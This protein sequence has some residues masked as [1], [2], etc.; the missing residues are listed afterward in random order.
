MVRRAGRWRARRVEARAR[1]RRRD[2]PARTAS[3]PSIS[4]WP[5][6][7]GRSQGLSDAARLDAPPDRSSLW[8]GL[9]DLRDTLLG[10]TVDDLRALAARRP[11]V[12]GDRCNGMPPRITVVG[13]VNLDLVVRG[14]AAAAAGGDGRRRRRSRVPG[15]KGANQA[16]ACAR[17][18]ADVTLV[19]RG[20]ARPFA[21]EALAGLREGGVTL[22]AARTDAAD[23]SRGDPGRRGGRDHDRGRARRQRGA[24][25]G[26]AAAA[27]RGA[28]PARG[29]RRGG[30]RGLGGVRRALLPERRARAA[31][32]LS[33]PT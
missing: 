8:A 29:A 27:R 20:R 23:R 1:P 7:C 15:G 17:L 24:R 21:D 11:P 25:R 13:S 6:S 2:M 4:S 3:R 16:V 22:D 31:A 9:F 28:L 33:T 19:V 32:S 5:C 30:A 10:S 26:R 12:R 14:R 18:G